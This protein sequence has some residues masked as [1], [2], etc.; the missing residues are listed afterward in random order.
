MGWGAGGGTHKIALCKTHGLVLTLQKRQNDARHNRWR[1]RGAINH[2]VPHSAKEA[3]QET[4]LRRRPTGTNLFNIAE[5]DTCVARAM[6]GVRV[7]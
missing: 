7:T 2:H 3:M 5:E 6:Y 4:D 1:A